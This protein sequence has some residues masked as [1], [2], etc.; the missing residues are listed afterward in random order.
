MRCPG[1]NADN[2]P[3]RRFCAGCGQPLPAACPACGF[4]NAPDDRFCG[5]CGKPL[6]SATAPSPAPTPLPE[7]WPPE[8]G[9]ADT[10]LGEIRPVTVMF[11][12]ISGYTALS[13]RMDAED[14]HQ[15]LAR[16]FETVDAIVL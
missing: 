9:T 3:G 10:P 7:A 12:D 14:T 11:V 5:G 4:E 2:R 16:F 8:S 6:G 15:L 1:C 13:G